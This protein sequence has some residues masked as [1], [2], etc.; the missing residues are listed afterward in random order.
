MQRL[1]PILSLLFIIILLVGGVWCYFTWLQPSVTFMDEYR[2][3]QKHVKNIDSLLY[4]S[5][6]KIDSSL[7]V[8]QQLR[9]SVLVLKKEQSASNQ[10]VAQT[11]SKMQNDLR[12]YTKNL[13]AQKKNLKNKDA[14]IDSLE[15]ELSK[16]KPLLNP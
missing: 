1:A 11:I 13:E 6:R 16:R 7:Q 8:M 14:Q 15:N 10:T 9:D 3:A 4:V 2:R 12:F 5:D